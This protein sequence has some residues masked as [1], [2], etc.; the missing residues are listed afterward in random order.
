MLRSI[1]NPASICLLTLA[2]TTLAAPAVGADSGLPKACIDGLEPGW[3]TL[4]EADFVNV[5]CD[6]DTWS[7]EDGRA[8][9]TGKPI[10]VIRSVKPLTNFELAVEWKHLKRS[11]NSGVFLWM[12]ES[13]W[14]SLKRN[15]LPKGI[16]CQILDHG[17]AEDYEEKNGKKS[18]W[19]TTDGDVFPTSGAKMTPFPPTAPNSQRSFPSEE[20]TKGFGNWNHYYIRA[21]NG[22]VR[23]WVN[24]REVSGGTGCEPSSGYLALESEGSP[25]EFRNL[26]IRELP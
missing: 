8:K 6:P 19:F 2:A 16:E 20:R 5:N 7:W 1:F 24:G 3:R 4:G 23:L 11:G 9:C 21:I 17:Y 10:G 22:E 18:D 25:I 26:R 13:S 15:Q 12:P 14:R